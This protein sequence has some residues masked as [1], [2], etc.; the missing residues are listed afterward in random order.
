MTNSAPAGQSTT[1]DGS[2]DPAVSYTSG[3]S[4]A[5]NF[6]AALGAKQSFD[7]TMISTTSGSSGT[8]NGGGGY[9]FDEG[10]LKS[11]GW[12]PSSEVTVNGASFALPAFGSSTSGPDNLLAANQTIGAS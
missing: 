4:L 5:A 2:S 3:G 6:A 10:L 11:A 1:F 12:N 8:A 7:N 9:S